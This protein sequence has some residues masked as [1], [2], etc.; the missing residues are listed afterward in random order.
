MSP[1]AMPMIAIVTSRVERRP[2]RSPRWPKMIAPTGRITNPT[3][4]VAN[5]ARV[6]P[7]APRGSKNSGPAK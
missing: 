2:I 1:V 5:A 3:P 7:T 4:I 6:P